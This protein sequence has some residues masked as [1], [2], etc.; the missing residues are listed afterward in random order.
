[1]LQGL[2]NVY[3]RRASREQ[4]L[5]SAREAKARGTKDINFYVYFFRVRKNKTDGKTY[6][7]HTRR[8]AETNAQ[9]NS[10]K[11]NRPNLVRAPEVAPLQVPRDSPRP[12]RLRVLRVHH[13]LHVQHRPAQAHPDLT[14]GRGAFL[15]ELLRRNGPGLLVSA[16]AAE[17]A[18]VKGVG[19][20]T[21]AVSEVG[22]LE[23]F[24]ARR[25]GCGHR[26]RAEG[27]GG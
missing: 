2:M 22:I 12:R 5:T 20:A 21:S 4:Q 15:Q 11:Q 25:C 14:C 26:L 24:P 9:P 18:P 8:R 16:H 1:M 19:V 6:D 27:G 13:Q 23:L 3:I 10:R 7:T 17:R